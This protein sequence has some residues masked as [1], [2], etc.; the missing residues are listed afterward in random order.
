MRYLIL[1]LLKLVPI[2]IGVTLITFSLIFLSPSDP[3]KMHFHSQGAA[4]T[5]KML[6][7]FREENGLNE[8]FINQYVNWGKK[9]IR[10]D[11]GKSYQDGTDIKAK[12]FK[13]APYTIYMS[14]NAVLFT[15]IISVP[16]GFYMAYR[17]DSYIS[18]F[19]INFSLLGISLPNF[20][21]A[22]AVM[23]LLSS[24]LKLIPVLSTDPSVAIIMPTITLV[25]AMSSKYIRQIMSITQK[26]LD[27]EYIYGLRARGISDFKI[28][29]RTVLKNTG[30]EILTLV[31]VSIGSLLGGVAIIETIFNWP[32]LGK[33]M[34]EAVVTRDIPLIQAI[35]VLISISYVVIN[36]LTDICYGLF[37]PRIRLEGDRL[38]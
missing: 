24:K 10:G 22:L 33:L 23:F 36:L 16:L 32:G 5:E 27:K 1:R 7:D 14:I 3:A 2:I 26:E 38:D 11:F 37:D 35:V 28:I 8:G 31:G 29:T 21:I 6:E 17:P 15:L 20:V 34:V 12:V 25:I 9:F 19:L 4:Y 30:V 13:S 18:K